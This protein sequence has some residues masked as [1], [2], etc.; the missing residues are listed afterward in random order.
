MLNVVY[1]RK[2]K[3]QAMVMECLTLLIA[4]ERQ[5]KG[6][7]SCC[8]RTNGSPSD[9]TTN[10]SVA[11][12]PAVPDELLLSQLLGSL[13]GILDHPDSMRTSNI[14]AA[15][16]TPLPGEALL[17]HMLGSSRLAHGGIE[18]QSITY[19][20]PATGIVPD[21]SLLNQLLGGLGATPDDHDRICTTR[22]GGSSISSA[23]PSSE[24]AMEVSTQLS[25]YGFENHGLAS[26]DPDTFH[27]MLDTTEDLGL[28]Y[29]EMKDDLRHSF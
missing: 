1:G 12:A 13:N 27:N 11:R 28:G 15:A 18:G 24:S 25:M 6:G 16:S 17:N 20:P 9:T 3:L 23:S 19:T 2:E 10:I 4:R 8:C 7:S 5:I 26:L 14:P 22:I 21:E 29:F